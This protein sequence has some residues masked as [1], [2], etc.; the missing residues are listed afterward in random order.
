M[1]SYPLSLG[2]KEGEAGV[3]RLVGVGGR[4]VLVLR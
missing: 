3:Y 4:W 1:R 2:L